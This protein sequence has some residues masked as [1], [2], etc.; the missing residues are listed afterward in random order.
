MKPDIRHTYNYSADLWSRP[1]DDP[2][3][4][5][6]EGNSHL[7]HGTLFPRASKPHR[8]TWHSGLVLLFVVLAALVLIGAR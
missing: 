2:R 3:Q 4:Y 8:R 1:I 6:F 7:P 5:E